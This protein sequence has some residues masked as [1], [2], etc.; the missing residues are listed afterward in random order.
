MDIIEHNEEM[1]RLSSENDS[2]QITEKTQRE[3]NTFIENV[4]KMHEY[5]S[6]ILNPQAA[7]FW[8]SMRISQ[9]RL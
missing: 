5:M 4:N 3:Y 2:E 7:D 8:R 6:E 9:Y 1:E